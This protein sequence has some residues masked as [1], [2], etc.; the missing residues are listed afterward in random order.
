MEWIIPC[1]NKTYRVDEAFRLLP[2][3]EWHQSERHKNIETGDTAYIYESTPIKSIC[4]KCKVVDSHRADSQIDDSRFF[5]PPYPSGT[6]FP[7]PF[8]VLEPEYEYIVGN[9]LSYETLKQH[10]LKS[11]LMGPQRVSNEL[12]QYIHSLDLTAESQEDDAASMPLA[13]LKAVAERYSNRPVSKTQSSQVVYSRNPYIS[14]YVKRRAKGVCQLCGAIAPFN[15]TKGNP[16]LE[17]HHIVW[18]S[19]GGPDSIDNTV[20][21][22]PNCHRRVHILAASEDVER[23][24]QL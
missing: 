12:S 16:Y 23:L 13:E 19:K 4:W 1:N 8:F 17:T 24:K 10:G 5:V 20:A 14:Q 7:G 15:D 2:Q 3:V 22:C 11:R 6:Q 18:L 21:L 9:R